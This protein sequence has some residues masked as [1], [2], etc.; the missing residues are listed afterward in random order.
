MKIIYLS[1]PE[2]GILPLE[3]LLK[4]KK[5]E[6]VA[7]IS[8]PDKPQSRGKKINFTPIKQYAVE[9]G[10]K[11]YQFEKLSRD[12][13]SVIKEINPDIMIT[14]SYGQIISQQII[15]IPKYGIINIHG[16]L[17]PK[18][19][20][21]S[22]VQAAILNGDT[23]TGVTI[24]Q[25]EAGLDTGD[26]LLVK[27]TNIFENETC[28]ELM[29][30]LSQIGADALIE[31]LDMIADGTVERR[32][33]SHLEATVT[34]VIS[35]EQG[36]IF[37]TKS[38]EQI[39]NQ[40]HAYNPSPVAF[41]YLNGEK[42]K[43]YNARIFNYDTDFDFDIKETETQVG[44]VISPTS[45]KHGLFIKC[46]FGILEVLKI[47][48]PSGKVITGAEAVGGRKIKIG[49]IFTDI[50]NSETNLILLSADSK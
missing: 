37:W 29:M 25:T 6:V 48:F 14:A 15:N 50:S 17:L 49:D 46:G 26:I 18:Y 23:E 22:P 11:V 45:P 3:A 41:S 21:A 12:G 33:Q 32:K 38:S 27:K 39:K 5:H 34:R 7:V 35:K 44:M 28:G 16:S 43:F 4:S 31:V 19:R 30:R 9:R 8:Q 2:F 42:V 40:I 24:M 1:T 13:L 36:I 10:I 20:G 47:Q